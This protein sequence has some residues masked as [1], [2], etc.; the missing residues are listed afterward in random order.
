MAQWVLKA[1]GN[2]VPRRSLR[3]LKAEEIHAE[4]EIKKRQTF[5]ALIERRWGP[6][7]NPPKVS[8]KDDG[9]D[10]DTSDEF[11]H[12]EDDVEQPRI[13]PDIEDTVDANG[14]LLNQQPAYDTLLNAEVRMNLGDDLTRGTVKR[15]AAGADG[16]AI[17]TYDDNSMLNTMVYEVEFPDG[18][19]K[20]YAANLIA[21]NM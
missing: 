16:K 2:V 12:Y 5:D 15:R 14:R 20:E 6:S 17:G 10:L 11:E 13:V 9:V 3:P 19:V 8:E 18:Q 21:E 7:I 1:N 4:T